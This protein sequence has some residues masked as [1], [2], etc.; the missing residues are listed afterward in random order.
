MVFIPIHLAYIVIIRLSDWRRDI[1]H[2][3]SIKSQLDDVRHSHVLTGP[4]LRKR[5]RNAPSLVLCML[6][7]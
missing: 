4:R 2:Y 3:H 1:S 6:L 5:S 7:K